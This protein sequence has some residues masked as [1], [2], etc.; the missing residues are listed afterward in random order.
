MYD[1]FQTELSEFL[2]KENNTKEWQKTYVFIPD[3]F[4]DGCSVKISDEE[5]LLIGGLGKGHT[6]G[7]S[8]R[9]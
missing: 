9:F 3:G 1:S 7:Y 5:L 8:G 6:T 2:P 4:S